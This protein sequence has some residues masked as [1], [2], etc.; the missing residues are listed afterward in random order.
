MQAFLVARIRVEPRSLPYAHYKIV[1]GCARVQESAKNVSVLTRS[2]WLFTR[3]STRQT[4]NCR[5]L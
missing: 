2:A 5:V 1:K 3:L 4:V